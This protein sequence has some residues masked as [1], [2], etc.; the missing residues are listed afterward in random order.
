MECNRIHVEMEEIPNS[1]ENIEDV[2]IE[3]L[4]Y[5]DGD[6][7]IVKILNQKCVIC[8]ERDSEYIFKQCGH[9]CFCQECYENKSDVDVLKCVICRTNFIPFNIIK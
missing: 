6:N 7:E 2:D 3:D 9:Q 5:T 8:L 4:E 1:E